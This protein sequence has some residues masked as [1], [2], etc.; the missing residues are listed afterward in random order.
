[1]TLRRR[2]EALEARQAGGGPV[3]GVL[4]QQAGETADEAVARARAEGR[5][6]PWI[7]LPA[8]PSVEEWERAT[9]AQQAALVERARAVIEDDATHH[10]H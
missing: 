6:G 5:R 10:L 4:V 8:T 3:G 9:R 7:V 1:M 2:L